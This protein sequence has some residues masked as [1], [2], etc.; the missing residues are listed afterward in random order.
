MFARCLGTPTLAE[1]VAASPTG[2]RS[3]LSC[4]VTRALVA[5]QS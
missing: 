2:N 4:V 5:W 3:P 1:P